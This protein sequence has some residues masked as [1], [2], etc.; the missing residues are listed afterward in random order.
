MTDDATNTSSNAEKDTKDWV[1]GDE[2]AT[3]AQESYVHTLAEQ[4]NEEVPEK[5]TKAQA[6][7][8]IAELQKETGRGQ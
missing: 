7:D 1:T 8:M 4:A 3:G 5:L 2:P 6:S